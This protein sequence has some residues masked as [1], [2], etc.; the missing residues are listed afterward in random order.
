MD[1]DTGV[2]IVIS[3][4]AGLASGLLVA[5]ANHL[6]ARRKTAAETKKLEAEAEKIRLETQKLLTEM[7]ALSSTVKEVN[8][9]LGESKERIIYDG[10]SYC[11]G[12]HFKWKGDRFYGESS[13]KP[14]AT[15]SFKVEDGILNIKRTNTDGRFRVTLLRYLYDGDVRDYLPRNELV[16]GR[17]QLKLRCEVKTVGGAH[18]LLF[19]MKNTSGGDHL[20]KHEE[21]F[22]RNEWT[23]VEIFFRIP[24]HEN[25]QLWIDDQNVLNP[26]SSFQLRNLLLAEINS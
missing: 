14:I 9:K 19:I 10:E 20:D 24:P 23:K 3:I 7:A 6:L 1:A 11:D 12:S 15:G 18:T 22:Y 5:V 17:R 26:K 25:C 13:D 21:T 2:K 8:Y 4:T 16:A